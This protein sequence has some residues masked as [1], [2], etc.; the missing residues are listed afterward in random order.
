[1]MKLGFDYADVAS[2]PLAEIEGYLRAYEEIVKPAAKKTYLVAR[3]TARH[4]KR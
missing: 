1:M 3:R 4:N 2:M